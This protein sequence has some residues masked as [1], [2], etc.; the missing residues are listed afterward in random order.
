MQLSAWLKVKDMSNS[1]FARRIGGS[2]ALI[3]GYLKRT[4]WPSRPKM[5][6]IICVTKGEVTP[7][8]IYGLKEPEAA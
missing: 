7:N 2:P 3:D 5:K 1:E 8:D 4:I 6:R